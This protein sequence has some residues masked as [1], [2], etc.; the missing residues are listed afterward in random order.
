MLLDRLVERWYCLRHEGS[1]RF[2]WKQNGLE[3]GIVLIIVVTLPLESD[4]NFPVNCHEL[5]THVGK[6]RVMHFE[7][8]LNFLILKLHEII[9]MRNDKKYNL[10]ACFVYLEFLC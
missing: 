8:R 5:S 1:Q 4:V 6:L 3:P 2:N 10:L 7:I 9:R